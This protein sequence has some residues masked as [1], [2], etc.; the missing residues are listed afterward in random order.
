MVKIISVASA[1]G[2]VGKTVTVANLGVALAG[3]FKKNVVVIDCNLSNPHL[4]LYLGMFSTWPVTLNSVLNNEA[5][6]EKA[7]HKHAT[8]LRVIPASFEV[9]DLQGMTLQRLR[10]RIRSTFNGYDTDMVILDSSPGI[11]KEAF[12]TVRA[13]DEILFVA[14]PHIPAIV[15]ITKCCHMLKR[16]DANPVGIAM[17]RVRNQKYELRDEEVYKFTKLPILAKIPEDEHV[18]RSTNFKIPVVSMMPRAGASRAFVRLAAVISGEEYQPPGEGIL[19]R[20][21]GR[22]RGRHAEED[23][24]FESLA[25]S[26]HDFIAHPL[27]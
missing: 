14:T 5:D 25:K 16:T 11:T 21:F 7:M 20:L 13:A 17:N 3:V 1:K 18:L 10:S 6:L 4:G 26:R 8:G 12:L 24:G 2:G 23:A 9:R 19:A 27:R 22:F 15:D